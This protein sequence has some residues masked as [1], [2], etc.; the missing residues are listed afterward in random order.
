M[1]SAQ[2][3]SFSREVVIRDNESCRPVASMEKVADI[4][5]GFTS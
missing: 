3:A 4:L 5:A 1:D 2:Q